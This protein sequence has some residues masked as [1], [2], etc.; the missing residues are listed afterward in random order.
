MFGRAKTDVKTGNVNIIVMAF[1][2]NDGIIKEISEM[3]KKAVESFTVSVPKT[4]VLE[5]E[6]DAPRLKQTLMDILEILEAGSCTQETIDNLKNE[7]AESFVTVMKNV[8]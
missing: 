2:G 3:V 4:P 7:V 8:S 1:N 5:T 6:V